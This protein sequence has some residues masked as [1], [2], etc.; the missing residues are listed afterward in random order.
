MVSEWGGR[1][2]RAAHR[3]AEVGAPPRGGGPLGSRPRG[4]RAGESGKG[5]PVWQGAA[6]VLVDDVDFQ[7]PTYRAT[8][9]IPLMTLQGRPHSGSPSPRAH[10]LSPIMEYN[11]PTHVYMSVKP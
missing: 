1:R 11:D 4:G 7:F 9:G 3:T 6:Q 5:Q 8:S 2:V 10:S